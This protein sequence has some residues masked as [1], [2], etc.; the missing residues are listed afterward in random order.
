MI[1]KIFILTPILF[2]FN[3]MLTMPIIHSVMHAPK[4]KRL[5]P[6]QRNDIIER[7]RR[8]I[9]NNSPKRLRQLDKVST[10]VAT[11]QRSISPLK[12]RK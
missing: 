10:I 9:G 6:H 11:V 2:F 3:V 1:K 5:S 12:T 4:T 8:D 7:Q